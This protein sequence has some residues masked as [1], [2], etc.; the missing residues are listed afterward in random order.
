MKLSGI[1]LV[2]INLVLIAALLLLISTALAEDVYEWTDENGNIHFSDSPNDIPP[3]YQDQ[4]KTRKFR[5]DKSQKKSKSSTDNANPEKPASAGQGQEQ[6]LNRYEIPFEGYE[7]T[8]KRIIISVTFND[9]VKASMLLDTGATGMLISPSLA[10]KLGVFDKSQGKLMIIT[11]GIGGEAPGIRTI[12]DRA[13]VGGAKTQFIPTTV[14]APISNSFEG[15]IG[16]DFMSNY[17]IN[18]DYEKKVVVLNEIFPDPDSPGG[19]DENWWRNTFKE[20]S[21]YHTQCKERLEKIDQEIHKLQSIAP[22]DFT[23]NKDVM[24]VRAFA[25]YQSMHADKLLDQLERYAAQNS[26]PMPWRREE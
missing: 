16:M 11:G 24:L 21:A 25:E 14:T 9:S 20:F 26:V 7:G 10:E 3:K 18:I 2:A 8:A 5:E 13:E 1:H 23:L 4:F 15:L 19:H 6:K 22:I 12:I 17:N